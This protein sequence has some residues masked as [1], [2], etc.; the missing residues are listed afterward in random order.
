MV[1]SGMEKLGFLSFKTTFRDMVQK[2]IKVSPNHKDSVMSFNWH[3]EA[4]VG[5]FAL[6]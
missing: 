3:E 1:L 5:L 6:Y 2:K 4:L